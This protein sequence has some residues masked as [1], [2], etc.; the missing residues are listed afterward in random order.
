MSITKEEYKNV[1]IHGNHAFSILAVYSFSPHH[2]SMDE[3]RYVLVRDP[4]SYS[5]YAE[6]TLN[7][8]KLGKLRSI[9]SA[10]RSSG[11]F[12]ISWA[13]FSRYFTS[14]TISRYDAG[15]YEARETGKFT[16]NASESLFNYHFE[17]I[18]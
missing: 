12:W 4:H 11:A 7:E 14:I 18:E 6:K 15:M 3:W 2:S 1:G 8:T 10:D 13:S 17:L 9:H 16:R 5:R